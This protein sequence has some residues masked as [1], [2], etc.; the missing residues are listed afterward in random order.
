MCF[1]QKE[2]ACMKQ[3]N[4]TSFLFRIFAAGIILTLLL[5]GTIVAMQSAEAT[6]VSFAWMPVTIPA[7][8]ESPSIRLT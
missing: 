1:N 7:V 2:N 3:K 6:Q 4:R 5:V 8:V